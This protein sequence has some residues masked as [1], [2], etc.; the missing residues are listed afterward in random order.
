MMPVILEELEKAGVR[1]DQIRFV[2]ALGAHGALNRR[3]FVKKLGEEAASRFPV[4]NH[5]IVGNCT[6]VGTT[7]FGTDLHINTEVVRCDYKIA[8]D[9][10]YLTAFAGFG[11]AR[12]SFCRA[13]PRSRPSAPCIG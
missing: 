9:R 8:L 13:L 4:F 5:N 11:A 7:S 2:C 1:D 3:D 6:L 12:R 10:S